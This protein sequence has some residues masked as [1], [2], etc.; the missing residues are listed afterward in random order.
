MEDDAGLREPDGNC[1]K[2]RKWEGNVSACSGRAVKAGA[3]DL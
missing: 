1:Q 3:G 2:C